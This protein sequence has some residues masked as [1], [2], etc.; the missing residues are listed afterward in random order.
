MEIALVADWKRWPCEEAQLEEIFAREFAALGHRVHFAFCIPGLVE[1]SRRETWHGQP[2]TLLRREGGQYR[3]LNR[4]LGAL[5]KERPIDLVQVR[6]DPGYSVL[7]RSL[8]RKAGKPFVFH[9]TILN[10]PVL[11]EEATEEPFPRSLLQKIK[12]VVGGRMVDRVARSCD[13][14]LPIS[15]AMA[16]HYAALGR[17]G[18]T[19]SLPMGCRGASA[20][21]APEARPFVEAL[22]VGALDRNRRL[23]FLLRAF[24][25]ARLAAPAL[26]LAFIGS[27]RRP[28]SLDWLKSRARELGVEDATRFERPVPRDEVP[29]RIARADFC[30]SPV[31]PTPYFLLSSPTKL[32]ES[33]GVGRP[34]VANDIPDQAVLLAASGGGLCVPY[35]MAA[36]GD[37]MAALAEDPARREAMGRRGAAHMA[38]HRDYGVLARRALDAYALVGVK[39]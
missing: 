25:R 20:W 24:S 4:W 33:L 31:P 3:R 9:L 13:L 8:A 17:S 29:G 12:G 5:L 22:Y 2:V 15:E 30:V 32:M 11:V 7:A 18:P 1:E 34:V 16:A 10:G 6:N 27:A 28:A 23:D 19:V 26:R 39:A 35:D 36:F 38:A 21:P 14:L 37:A